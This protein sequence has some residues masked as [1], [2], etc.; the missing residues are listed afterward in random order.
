MHL[1]LIAHNRRT[2]PPQQPGVGGGRQR[3]EGVVEGLMGGL[4]LEGAVDGWEMCE[5][6]QTSR[7]RPKGKLAHLQLLW[8]EETGE[9]RG[10]VHDGHGPPQVLKGNVLTRVVEQRRRLWAAAGWRVGRPVQHPHGRRRL[11]APTIAGRSGSGAA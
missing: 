5:S 9:G 10:G 11:S 6:S 3:R 7:S 8:F 1:D 4:R 2:F